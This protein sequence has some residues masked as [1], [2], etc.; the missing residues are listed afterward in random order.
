MAI[1]MLLLIEVADASARYDR[2]IKLPLYARHGVVEVWIVDLEARLVRFFRQPSGDR[3]T[4]TT[5][6]AMPGPTPVAALDGVAIDLG[7][8]LGLRGSESFDHARSSRQ[9]ASARR[10]KCSP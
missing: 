6:T 1:D 4:D 10:C 2:E 5:S 3:Y 9:K 7:G 8:V